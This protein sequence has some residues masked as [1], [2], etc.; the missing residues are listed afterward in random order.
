MTER[1]IMVS[2]CGFCVSGLQA[3]S[4]LCAY[5]S[6][7]AAVRHDGGKFVVMFIASMVVGLL[8]VAMGRVSMFYEGWRR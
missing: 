1:T 6:G 4:S 5:A 8:A 2:V 7:A 3:I